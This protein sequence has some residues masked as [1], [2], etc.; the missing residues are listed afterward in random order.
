MDG[1]SA[2]ARAAMG[3]FPRSIFGLKYRPLFAG[4][5]LPSKASGVR[6]NPRLPLMGCFLQLLEA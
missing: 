3:C 5:S 2:V 4:H 6:L 1:E